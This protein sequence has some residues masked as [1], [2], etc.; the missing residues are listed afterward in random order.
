VTYIFSALVFRLGLYEAWQAPLTL[1]MIVLAILIIGCPA[2]PFA[3][4]EALVRSMA[5]RP[6]VSLALIV[7][8][9]IGGPLALRPWL[10]FPDPIISDEFSLLLQAKTYLLGRL[11]NPIHLTPNFASEMTILSPTYSSQ[12]PALRS[13]PI[14]VGYLAGVGAWGGVVLCMAALTAAVYWI[15]VFHGKGTPLRG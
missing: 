8:L 10:G 3:R 15:V 14:L 11:A 1:A 4:L 12:Y 5:L 7:L 13:F 9:A 2:N 6:Y